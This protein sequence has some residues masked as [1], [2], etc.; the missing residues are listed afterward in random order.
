MKY[1]VLLILFF[2]SFQTKAQNELQQLVKTGYD[3]SLNDKS[4]VTALHKAG[5]IL[6]D[7]KV[8]SALI[9]LEDATL[10]LKNIRGIDS[11]R[12]AQD[13]NLIRARAYLIQGLYPKALE[14]AQVA[15]NYSEKLK[16]NNLV[17]DCYSV[18]G[19]IYER[20]ENN[21]KAEEYYKKNLK[22]SRVIGDSVRI[23]T[24]LSLLGNIY[25]ATKRYEESL[26]CYNESLTFI[27][28]DK[29][30][31]QAAIAYGNIGYVYY[32]VGT[33]EQSKNELESKTSSDY[34]NKSL[35]AT[36]NAME[37]F[38]KIGNKRF[39]IIAGLNT[40]LVYNQMGDYATAKKWCQSAYDAAV[41]LK[42]PPLRSDACECLYKSNKAIGNSD[43]ALKYFEIYK[44]ISD[45][46]KNTDN[47]R[48]MVEKELNFN[49]E[50]EKL[51]DSLQ[52]AQKEAI[53]DSQIQ[54]QRI[55][56]ISAS[57]IVVLIVLLMVVL[58][59]GKK[60]SEEL[61]L[62]ILPFD[63]AQEL[64]KK[65]MAETKNFDSVTVLFTDFKGFTTISE[66][67]SPKEL[68]TEIDTC[69]KGIDR[70]MG[71]YNIEKIKT[72]GDAYMAAGGLPTTN[73]THP[74]DVVMAAQEIILFME[75]LK[76]E[77]IKNNKPFFEIRIGIH[78]G[79]VI[80]GIVGIKKFSYDIWGDTVNTA[81]RLESSGEVNK[82]NL[83]GATYDLI[84]DQYQCEHR[85]KIEAKNKGKI[86]MY[87][88]V[89]KIQHS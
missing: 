48:S 50:K 58:I 49:Y 6:T 85:G 67:L 22:L 78:T 35:E 64:K 40:G 36:N 83:S 56:L 39:Q 11:V 18:I 23:S 33:L 59:K 74:I 65:G 61:L 44:Q 3:K 27:N 14:Y 34:F 52:Y 2:C 89:G 46:I 24:S 81:S 63:T 73:T 5:S 25:G 54:K 72:I 1:I 79:P 86:D 17:A 10:I 32:E 8:D 15:M 71:K 66:L 55:G 21:A 75:S 16:Q 31:V 70:I 41:D 13:N 38:K 82:I 26:K 68:V 4:R 69:F 37:I 60:R 77:R 47:E 43:E 84:K 42:I 28:P 80:A 88:L 45:S 76:Q 29:N 20:Q 53:A 9:I 57:G 62:N 87:F 19:Q 12:F 30:P 7:S 51:S